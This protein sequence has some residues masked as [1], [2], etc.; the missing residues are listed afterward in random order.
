MTTECRMT[1]GRKWL[2]V[3]L[4]QGW[5]IYYLLAYHNFPPPHPIPGAEVRNMAISKVTQQE[6]VPQVEWRKVEKTERSKWQEV[7]KDWR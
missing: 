5:I 1:E 2:K 4:T 6:I 7:E 3:F